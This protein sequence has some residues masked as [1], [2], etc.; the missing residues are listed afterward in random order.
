MIYRG[1]LSPRLSNRRP[2]GCP[3]GGLQ[4]C[5]TGGL[6]GCPT[7]GLQGCRWWAPGLSNRAGW[8]SPQTKFMCL[9]KAQQIKLLCTQGI[10]VKN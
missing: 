1:Y 9:S 5:P 2:Q 10:K 8:A 6:Q 3:T 4:G 7:G